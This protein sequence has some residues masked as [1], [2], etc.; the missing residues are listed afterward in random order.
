MQQDGRTVSVASQSTTTVESTNWTALQ[1]AGVT[2]LP[3]A[4]RQ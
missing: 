1:L 3:Q 2:Q 4:G